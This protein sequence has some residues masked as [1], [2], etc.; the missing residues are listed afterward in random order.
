MQ[1]L[2]RNLRKTAL[3][4]L[5]SVVL[6]HGTATA[7]TPND[8]TEVLRAL[9]GSLASSSTSVRA[10]FGLNE[11]LAETEQWGYTADVQRFHQSSA[12]VT[13]RIDAVKSAQTPSNLYSLRIALGELDKHLSSLALW[14]YLRGVRAVGGAKEPHT[15]ALTALNEAASTLRTGMLLYDLAANAKLQRP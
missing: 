3:P 1:Q 13:R 11:T 4:F 2:V 7:Q 15:S 6:V 8:L 12:D 9:E 14:T 10:S 5:V